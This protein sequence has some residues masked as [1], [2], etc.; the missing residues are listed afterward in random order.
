M[1][2]HHSGSSLVRAEGTFDQAQALAVVEAKLL[3][4]LNGSET[5]MTAADWQA[6]REEARAQ[7]M[8]TG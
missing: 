7:V 1:P 8:A 6:L 4:G 5:T 2:Q 3:D